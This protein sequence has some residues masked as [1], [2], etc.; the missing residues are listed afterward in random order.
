[1]T[2]FD[3][4]SDQNIDIVQEQFFD[5]KWIEIESF[6]HNLARVKRLAAKLKAL[7]SEVKKSMIITKVLS[8]WLSKFSHFY[9]AWDFAP[10]TK[11]NFN[12]L[13]R[14]LCSFI[15]RVHQRSLPRLEN[16]G[17]G[18]SYKKST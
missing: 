13:T 8:K 2:L 1:M 17:R 12:T 14:K 11:K 6:A 5:F 9:S 4:K 7:E 3:S 15:D 18:K 16:A 10:E